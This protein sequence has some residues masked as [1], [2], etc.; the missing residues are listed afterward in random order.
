[1]KIL[2]SS[3]TKESVHVSLKVDTEWNTPGPPD[4]CRDRSGLLSTLS[5]PNLYTFV[6]E[7]E[8]R[9]ENEAGNRIGNGPKIE[10]VVRCIALENNV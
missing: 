6:A 7:F 8:S 1:M 4:V 2:A 5:I 9:I 10:A 3:K